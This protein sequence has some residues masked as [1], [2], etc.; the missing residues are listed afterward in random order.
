M[1]IWQ[2]VPSRLRSALYTFIQCVSPPQVPSTPT[3]RYRP[4]SLPQ[5]QELPAPNST[6]FTYYIYLVG[7]G[8]VRPADPSL[9][10]TSDMCTPIYPGTA[11]PT[12][13]PA[14]RPD[15]PF[16]FAGC[17]HWAGA[18]S[19][20]RVRVKRGRYPRGAALELPDDEYLRLEHDRA[21]D[22]FRSARLARVRNAMERAARRAEAA[23][24][25]EAWWREG[26]PDGDDGVDWQRGFDAASRRSFVDVPIGGDEAEQESSSSSCSHSE[27]C[28]SPP[29]PTPT[30]L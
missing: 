22:A 29:M 27:G 19:A 23:R 4:H 5:I 16:P 9:C 14:V 24:A 25:V 21:E 6:D 3:N 10:I 30:L 12:G 15:P 17:A 7:P 1:L 8:P 28:S 26:G 20:L 18:D 11:H 2:H 13:R